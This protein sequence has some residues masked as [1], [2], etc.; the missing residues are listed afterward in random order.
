LEK[1]EEETLLRRTRFGGM[2]ILKQ[3]VRIWAGLI[4]LR[5]GSDGEPF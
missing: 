5:I 4:W 2:M 3:E 1:Y